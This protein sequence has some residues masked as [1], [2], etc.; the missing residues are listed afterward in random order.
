M[1]VTTIEKMIK[2]KLKKNVSHWGYQG[3][4]YKAGDVFEVPERLFV[5][6]LMYKIKEKKV[7]KKKAIRK[8]EEPTSTLTPET[9]SIFDLWQS[10]SSLSWS[11]GPGFR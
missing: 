10:R 7:Q 8:K 9:R 4:R 6:Y 11:R 1:E 3:N 5:P 2:V